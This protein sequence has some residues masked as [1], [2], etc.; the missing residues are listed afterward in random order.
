MTPL[1]GMMASGATGSKQSSYESIASVVT[2][3]GQTSI[4]FTSIPATYKSLQIRI[5]ARR[6]NGTT[7]TDTEYLRFNSDSGSNYAFHYLYGNGSSALVSSSA[8]TSFIACYEIGRNGTTANSFGV[9][10]IDI[11]DY[12]S[13]TKNKTVRAF[14][15]LDLNGSGSVTLGSGLWM[16]TNAITDINI[17]AAADPMAAGS[18]FALYGIKG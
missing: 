16:N 14:F 11:I 10:I 2:T 17:N 1:L 18:T 7:G 8:S 3:A 13:T 15:G 4:T 5:L 6:S 9:S 12:A